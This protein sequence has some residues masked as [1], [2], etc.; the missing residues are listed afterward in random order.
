MHSSDGPERRR[1]S[2]ERPTPIEKCKRSNY[3]LHLVRSATLRFCSVSGNGTGTSTP[4]W[5]I[6]R[7]G[8][9]ARPSSTVFGG[10]R[11]RRCGLYYSVV[12]DQLLIL[13]PAT[14]APAEHPG[15]ADTAIVVR[16]ADHD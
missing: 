6:T 7:S 1:A 3:W 13:R 16:S 14:A 11:D 5:S 8:D 2:C 10:H 15:R 12:T 9:G 4:S